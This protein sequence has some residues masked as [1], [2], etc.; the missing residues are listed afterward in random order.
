MAKRAGRP[1]KL[2]P[3]LQRRIVELIRAGNYASVAAAASGIAERT[4]YDWLARGSREHHSIYAEFLQTIKEASARAEVEAVSGVRTADRG[5]QAH[6]TWLERRYPSRWGRRARLD[7]PPS[8][9][10]RVARPDLRKLSD[11]ELEQLEALLA[12]A[13]PAVA[14]E[15]DGDREAG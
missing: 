8:S 15:S 5:W 6:M 14:T 7:D 4:Y 13:E 3:Q 12:K 2:T 1:T 11:E 10:E 9:G